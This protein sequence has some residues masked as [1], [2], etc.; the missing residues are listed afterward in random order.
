MGHASAQEKRDREKAFHGRFPHQAQVM[1][2]AIMEY[3]G[4]LNAASRINRRH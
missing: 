3:L 1:P 4:I 2:G